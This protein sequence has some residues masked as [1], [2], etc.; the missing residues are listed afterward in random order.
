LIDENRHS[1]DS[2][3]KILKDYGG[4]ADRRDGER[5]AMRARRAAAEEARAKV[6]EAEH[7]FPVTGRQ[8]GRPVGKR[9][10]MQTVVFRIPKEIFDDIDDFC[11]HYGMARATWFIWAVTTQHLTYKKMLKDSEGGVNNGNKRI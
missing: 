4:L 11:E 6:L 9:D 3:Q 1:C 2:P 7:A 8:V 10:D 5:E